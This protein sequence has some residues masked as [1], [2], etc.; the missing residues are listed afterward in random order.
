MLLRVHELAE[1]VSDEIQAIR[2]TGVLLGY[3]A[4]QI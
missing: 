3:Y 4:N 2:Q 1:D